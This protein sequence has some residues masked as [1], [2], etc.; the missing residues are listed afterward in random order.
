MFVKDALAQA[1]GAPAA[2]GAFDIVSLLPL[3]LIF[4]V[5]YFLLIR[6]QQKKMREHRDVIASLKRGDKV[7]TGGGIVGTIV[8]TEEGKPVVTVEIA[9][10]VRID[11]VRSTIS[12]K[13]VDTPPPPANQDKGAPA[14]SGGMF[15]RLLGKK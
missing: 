7:I 3:V 9:P 10:N 4:V 8:R 6:P 13:Y 12:D 14:A 11:V 2:G 15:G 1:A 5:F